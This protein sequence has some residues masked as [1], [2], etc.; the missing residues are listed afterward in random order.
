MM[1]QNLFGRLGVR[2]L[3][4]MSNACLLNLGWATRANEQ[5]RSYEV[6]SRK[7]MRNNVGYY[8]VIVKENAFTLW[9]SLSKLWPNFP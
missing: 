6:M 3:D 7:Y 4:V 1:L 2:W 8:D 5:S 9:K